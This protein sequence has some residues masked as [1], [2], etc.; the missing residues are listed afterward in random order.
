MRRST[1]RLTAPQKREPADV[2][3]DFLK[4]HGFIGVA[5]GARI[6]F[7]GVAVRYAMPRAAAVAGVD[8]T[9]A[10]G[11]FAVLLGPSGCGK[12][13]LLRTI[14]RLVEPTSGDAS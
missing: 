9:I 5:G 11:T 2:A 3:R 12:S 6:E 1:S 10:A 7:R 14:N 4:Q 13:T 8:L